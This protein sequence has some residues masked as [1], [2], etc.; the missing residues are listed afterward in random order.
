MILAAKVGGILA[1]NNQP[2]DFILENLKIQTN[3]I[4][5]SQRYKVKNF[6]FLAVVVFILNLLNNQL[7]RSPYLMDS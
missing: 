4:E 7:L 6:Y 2:A 1:N 5:I 3:L